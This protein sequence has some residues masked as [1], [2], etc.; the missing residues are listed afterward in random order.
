MSAPN[1]HERVLPALLDRLTDDA[2]LLN[3]VQVRT[4]DELLAERGLGVEDLVRSM[5]RAGYSKVEDEDPTESPAVPQ[6][7]LTLRFLSGGGATPANAAR[8]VELR[9]SEGVTGVE[10]QA[11]CDVTIRRVR[12][13][14]PGTGTGPVLS[15]RELRR[16]VQRD[17]DWL[18]N[19]GSLEP[20]TDLQRYPEI[21]RSVLNFGM[22]TLSGVIGGTLDGAQL[23]A[24]IQ[25][26]LQRFEPRLSHVRVTPIAATDG[27]EQ[28]EFRIDAELW[29]TPVSQAWSARTRIDLATGG[30][31]VV[32]AGG[33]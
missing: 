19:A 6:V 12:N 30:I 15:M 33:G 20:G 14:G 18:L 11:C 8:R 5:E 29:G 2:R 17:L 16:I 25:E 1:R 9:G 7:G 22:P 27:S 10:L 28:P 3:E 26:T 32:D 21:R 31:H 23:A 4:T 13:L 24:R